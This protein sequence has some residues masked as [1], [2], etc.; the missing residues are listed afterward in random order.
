MSDAPLHYKSVAELA[1]LIKSRKLSSLELTRTL[2]A[3]ITSL[4]ERCKS[5]ITPTFDI[6]EQQ[7]T[8]ADAEIAAGNYRGP[9]HGIPVGLKDAYDTA[10]IRTTVCS[11]VTS[12]RVP[13][14]D[15]VAWTKLR[16]AGA[17]L[18]GKLENTEFCLGG[19]SG[20]GLVP[21]ARN[22]W[23]PD[24]YAGG[25]SS[26]AGVALATGLIPAAMGTDTGGSIRIP[27]A[28]CGTA[29][30]KP[31]YGRVSLRGVFPLSGS[32]DHT[33][34]MARTSEDCALM[35]D[36]VSGHDPEHPTSLNAPAPGCA[37]ALT[38]D[39]KGLR[40]GHVTNFTEL[41]A[42]SDEHRA[43]TIDA[44]E[45]YRALGAEIIDVTLPDLWDFTVANSVIM[46]SEAY[47]IHEKWLQEQ[48]EN[49]TSFTRSRISMGAFIRAADYIN[50]QKTRRELALAT[51]K[52]MTSV[53]LLVFPGML[54]DPPIAKEI[55]PFYFLNSPL[56]TAPAN[57]AGV[58]SASVRCGFSKAGMPMAFQ[59]SGAMLDDATVL[60]GASAYEQ[61]TPEFDKRPID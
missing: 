49:Y 48:P 17:V 4:D 19:P 3:R 58:P 53:D 33:G 11:R 6:A 20:D 47:A 28:F 1:G 10:G 40:I 25:S 46:M 2:I 35:L 24:R 8:E 37:A 55:K 45:V 59:I 43:A 12:D 32:L 52:L 7:A 44:L 38:R 39:L 21:H 29:G 16:A 54:G 23:N 36:A 50:A 34:P 60:R 51:A 18:M 27:A 56:I 15:A 13:A 30:I 9:L 14:T 61:A 26:G 42:V 57:I 22:P 41:S 31:S 5:F